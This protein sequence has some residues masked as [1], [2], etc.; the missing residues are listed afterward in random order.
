MAV[1]DALRHFA[2]SETT[3]SERQ[4]WAGDPPEGFGV[5]SARISV[6]GR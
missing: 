4:H 1:R 6:S 3:A 5:S 2:E